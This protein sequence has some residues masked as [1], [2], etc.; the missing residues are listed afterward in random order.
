MCGSGTTGEAAQRL[1]VKSI[2]ADL[3]EDYIQIV[4]KRLGVKR[5]EL[6]IVWSKPL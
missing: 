2:L 6:N 5:I 4:E 1:G 3:N